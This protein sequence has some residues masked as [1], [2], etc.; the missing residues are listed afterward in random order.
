KF[1]RLHLENFKYLLVHTDDFSLAGAIMKIESMIEEHG[2][3]MTTTLL[4]N[5]RSVREELFLI[6][7]QAMSDE[8]MR[9]RTEPWKIYVFAAE[10]DRILQRLIK[11][12]ELDLGLKLLVDCQ[13]FLQQLQLDRKNRVPH[14]TDKEKEHLA[15]SSLSG[16][17]GTAVTGS[18]IKEPIPFNAGEVR[19][20]SEYMPDQSMKSPEMDIIN[21]TDQTEKRIEGTDSASTAEIVETDENQLVYGEDAGLPPSWPFSMNQPEELRSVI[22]SLM[23]ISTICNQE[24]YPKTSLFAMVGHMDRHRLYSQKEELSGILDE[25]FDYYQGNQVDRQFQKG[26]QE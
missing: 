9:R 19:S 11:Q 24:C 22:D 8:Y 14:K 13:N 4:I 5:N 20:L 12:K 17:T 2:R 15:T 25:L 18:Q 7:R 1:I 16:T 21:M 23:E 6:L 10:V 26:Q 3:E